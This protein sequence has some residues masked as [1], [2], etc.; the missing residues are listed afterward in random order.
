MS[1]EH[2]NED[3]LKTIDFIFNNYE[4]NKFIPNDFTST[5]C[6]LI[7]NL[8]LRNDALN[9]SKTPKGEEVFSCYMI[10]NNIWSAY[11]AK[12]A[13][14]QFGTVF[15]LLSHRLQQVRAAVSGPRGHVDL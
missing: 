7:N 4:V 13:K 5:L 3:V 14:N 12:M 2:T 9:D 15:P 11:E 8:Y 10:Y 1:S 6:L